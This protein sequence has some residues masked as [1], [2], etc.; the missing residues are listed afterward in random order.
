MMITEIL[1]VSWGFNI[2]TTKEERH[3][4]GHL[5]ICSPVLYFVSL[6]KLNLFRWSEWQLQC[7]DV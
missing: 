4:D 6:R 1:S 5:F 2:C 3:V 7:N